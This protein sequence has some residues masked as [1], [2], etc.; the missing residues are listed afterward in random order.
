LVIAGENADEMAEESMKVVGG[1]GGE[2]RF[3]L[4]IALVV[5]SQAKRPPPTLKADLY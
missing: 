2:L 1:G 4:P 3:C 5:V